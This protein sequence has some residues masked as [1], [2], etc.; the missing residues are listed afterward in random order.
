MLATHFASFV[1]FFLSALPRPSAKLLRA[2]SLLMSAWVSLTLAS[3]SS[4]PGFQKNELKRTS[5]Q[6]TGPT[7]SLTTFVSEQPMGREVK[8]V[9]EWEPNLDNFYTPRGIP[10]KVQILEAGQVIEPPAEAFRAS[11]DFYPEMNDLF[12]DSPGN[13]DLWI[14]N[15]V[16]EGLGKPPGFLI[17]EFKYQGQYNDHVNARHVKGSSKPQ[18]KWSDEFWKPVL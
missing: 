9:M 5:I 12:S 7:S 3:C 18:L 1:P 2:S 17:R 13:Y 8:L 16:G 14:P 15:G 10:L 4:G 6:E 11:D